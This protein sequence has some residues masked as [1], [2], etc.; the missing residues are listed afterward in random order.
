ME[1]RKPSEVKW[2]TSSWRPQQRHRR[3]ETKTTDSLHRLLSPNHQLWS[4]LTSCDQDRVCKQFCPKGSHRKCWLPEDS[5]NLNYPSQCEGSQQG[6]PAV[7]ETCLE[8]R[9][10]VREDLLSLLGT[11]Q[12]LLWFWFGALEPVSPFLL[13]CFCNT[14]KL[15]CTRF[16]QLF[17]RFL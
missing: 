1:N 15:P 7:E 16:H 11:S 6:D 4:P 10:R 5:V 13:L 14:K 12:Y 17:T 9:G 2:P 3:A 8:L